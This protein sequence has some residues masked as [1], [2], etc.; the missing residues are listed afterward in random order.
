[1]KRRQSIAWLLMLFAPSL[2]CGCGGGG[3]DSS[4]AAQQPALAAAP[5]PQPA[6][7]P[8]EVGPVVFVG[9][10]ITHLWESRNHCRH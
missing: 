7:Q 9:D 1:M 10:S 6:P 5:S 8:P 3:S 2:L 4:P